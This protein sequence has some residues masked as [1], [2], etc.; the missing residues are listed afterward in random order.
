MKSYSLPIY[1]VVVSLF[2]AAHFKANAGWLW[3]IFYDGLNW[4]VCQG[5]PQILSQA[6]SVDLNASTYHVKNWYADEKTAEKKTTKNGANSDPDTQIRNMSTGEWEDSID[7]VTVEGDYSYYDYLVYERDPNNPNTYI[8]NT[9]QKWYGMSFWDWDS[10]GYTGQYYI[11]F[12]I[13]KKV[14]A[15]YIVYSN[16][17]TAFDPDNDMYYDGT[18]N[19]EISYYIKD[20]SVGSSGLVK[21]PNSSEKTRIATGLDE[22]ASDSKIM[23]LLSNKEEMNGSPVADGYHKRQR[24]LAGVISGPNHPPITGVST[25]CAVHNISSIIVESG[26][27]H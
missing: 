25:G 14:D 8:A 5:Q 7:H 18:Y 11:S 20:V 13:T 10:S 2:F 23:D 22:D 4:I 16:T 27:S 24:A 17:T 6:G 21:T 15:N 9:D 12:G 1:S 19:I 3:D 26:T